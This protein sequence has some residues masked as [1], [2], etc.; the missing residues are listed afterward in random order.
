MLKQV[1]QI[2]VS[3]SNRCV[4]TSDNGLSEKIRHSAEGVHISPT[5]HSLLIKGV[6]WH[7]ST[8]FE[9]HHSFHIEMSQGL[10]RQWKWNHWDAIKYIPKVGSW[11]ILSHSFYLESHSIHL[12]VVST[13]KT[14]PLMTWAI[15]YIEVR[16]WNLHSCLPLTISCSLSTLGLDVATLWN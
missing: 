12:V 2:I 13:V 16:S 14:E 3:P 10:Y 8:F 6:I 11:I 5:C 9:N 4:I 1:K 15:T 7:S